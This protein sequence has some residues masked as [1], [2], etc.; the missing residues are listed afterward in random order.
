MP[1]PTDFIEIGLKCAKVRPTKGQDEEMPRSEP[2][3]L[4]NGQSTV[5]S[6]DRS[7]SESAESHTENN[8]I[9]VTFGVH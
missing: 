7:E 5:I 4:V 3:I 9:A 2:V 8:G 1:L 6:I